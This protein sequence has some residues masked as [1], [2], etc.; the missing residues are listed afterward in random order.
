MVERPQKRKRLARKVKKH[1]ISV[2]VKQEF[3]RKGCRAHWRASVSD[4]F[5]QDHNMQ[6]VKLN[7]TMNAMDYRSFCLDPSLLEILDQLSSL[8]RRPLFF[9]N[10]IKPWINETNVSS[11]APYL[12][13]I[14]VFRNTKNRV[15]FTTSFHASKSEAAQVPTSDNPGCGSFSKWN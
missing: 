9:P 12:Q 3:N 5:L 13:T 1:F 6:A 4:Q 8:V 2:D 15:T 7:K 11:N 10:A 14:W